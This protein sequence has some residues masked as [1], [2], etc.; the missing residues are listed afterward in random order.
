LVTEWLSLAT[1]DLEAAKHL[2]ST[3]RKVP[4]EIVCFH[5]QQAGEK[6]LKAALQS[7]GLDVPRTHD[8]KELLRLLNGFLPHDPA[9]DRSCSHLSMF[10]V[11]FR[12]P[13]MPDLVTQD[14]AT[15]I[16]EAAR[17][18]ELAKT[19]VAKSVG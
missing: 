16:D 4:I 5:C 3:M 8:L 17:I 10:G 12:Y 1:D 13:G 11:S 6:S 18:L 7:A 2:Y 14:A 15:A 9:I 19:V